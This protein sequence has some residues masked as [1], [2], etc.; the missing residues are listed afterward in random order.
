MDEALPTIGRLPPEWV[1]FFT[2]AGAIM[3]VA[4]GAL[5]WVFF[6]RKRVRRRRRKTRQHHEHRSPNPTLAQDGGLPP[7]RQNEK[8]PGQQM[9]N[10]Q[11]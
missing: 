9:P 2:M 4:I 8:P 10:T 7:V 11:P 6:L 3:L 5:I 1:D